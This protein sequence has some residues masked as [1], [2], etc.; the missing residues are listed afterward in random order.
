MFKLF[1]SDGNKAKIIDRVFMH[2][3]GKWNYC[4]KTLVE[5]PNTIFIGWFDATIVEL[6][7][8]IAR[9][10]CSPVT[11]LNA[12]STHRS[13]LGDSP[14]IFIEHHPLKSKEDLLF[15]ELGLKEAIILTAF[16]EPILSLFGGEKLIDIMQKL[17]LKEDEIIEHKLVSQS[18]ANA[19][20]KIEGKMVVEP[21]VRSQ[22]EWID[23]NSK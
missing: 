8:F 5:K 21:S 22:A 23:R 1:D 7:N 13:H 18:I 4:L 10:N 6:E 2:Q 17:G 20:K 19:Q 16:D 3:Q 9:N 14:I 15:S 12:R 11:I